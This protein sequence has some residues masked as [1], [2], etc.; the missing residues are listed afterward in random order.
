ML[1]EG[2]I[3]YNG[4]PKLVKDYFTKFG[5]KMGRFSNPADKLSNIAAEPKSVLGDQ[6]TIL[7]LNRQC[8]EQ[9]G[10]YQTLSELA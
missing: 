10:E 5:L 8:K 1:S 2:Y 9:L 7:E 3:I 6:M 4:P